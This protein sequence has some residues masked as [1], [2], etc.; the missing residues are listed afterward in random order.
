MGHDD[1]DL[2]RGSQPGVHVPPGVH[3]STSGGTFIVQPHHIT[4]GS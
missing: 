2:D 4:F 3:L 1:D